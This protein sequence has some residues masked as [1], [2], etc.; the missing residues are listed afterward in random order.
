MTSVKLTYFRPS[1]KYYT[2]GIYETFLQYDY[3]IY[4]EV[5]NFVSLHLV[6][7]LQSGS[8]DGPILIEPAGGVPALCNLSNE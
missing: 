2:E 6:P 8:W 5:S 1:G 4:Q 3:D 7:H